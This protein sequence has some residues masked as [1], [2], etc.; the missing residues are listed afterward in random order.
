M[1]SAVALRSDGRYQALVAG[2]AVAL[3]GTALGLLFAEG[4][5]ILLR[6]G[7][8][9]ERSLVAA[10][11]AG[12]ATAVGF[13]LTAVGYLFWA[14]RGPAYLGLTRPTLREVGLIIG[15]TVTMIVLQLVAG[16]FVPGP[17]SDVLTLLGGDQWLVFMLFAVFLINPA[18][19]LLF[20]GIVQSRFEESLGSVAAVLLAALFFA[21]A[22][23]PTYVD[24]SPLETLGLFSIQT[25]F[26][27]VIGAGY[28]V[29]GK[30]IVPIGIHAL[31]SVYL[32][33]LLFLG[34]G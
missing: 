29:T 5:G 13:T 28:A 17:E 2:S 7:Y 3:T 27:V 26:G 12:L 11:S 8:L 33:G 18:E 16:L 20:R 25:A 6:G 22:H 9:P 34:V 14:D 1:S 32:Y 23:V 19:E 10:V 4:A 15:L 31:Y 24:P 21:G 30:L